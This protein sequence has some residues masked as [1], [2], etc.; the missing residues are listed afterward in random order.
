VKS[1]RVRLVLLAALGKAYISGE[2]PD[3]VL[4]ETLRS[5]LSA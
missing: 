4:A 5:Y 1:G 3:A 2:Y